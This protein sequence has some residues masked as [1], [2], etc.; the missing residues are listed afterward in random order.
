M[1]SSHVYVSKH[2]HGQFWSVSFGCNHKTALEV[3]W[4]RFLQGTLFGFHQSS[5]NETF[6]A[7]QARDATPSTRLFFW[8][9]KFCLFVANSFKWE[10]PESFSG[11]PKSSLFEPLSMAGQWQRD[12]FLITEDPF[13]VDLVTLDLWVEG[14]RYRFWSAFEA[15]PE[16]KSTFWRSPY[17]DMCP[18]ESLYKVRICAIDKSQKTFSCQDLE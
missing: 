17:F 12:F 18:F 7:R 14:L 6:F 11:K 15:N 9:L 13:A 3:C 4:N 2:L 16:G 1:P 10:S 8:W 5:S